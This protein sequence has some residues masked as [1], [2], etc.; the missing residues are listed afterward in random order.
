MHERYAFGAL[1]FLPLAFPDR[2]A[3]AIALVFGIVFTLNLFAAAPPTPGIAAIVRDG[4]PLAI[5]GALTML[6][7]LAATLT[8]LR[9]EA[10]ASAAARTASED[11]SDSP[12]E[13]DAVPVQVVR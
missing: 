11:P 9:S 8:M 10:V 2:R 4:G 3:A 7:I 1:A 5:G 13:G 12:L 6:G